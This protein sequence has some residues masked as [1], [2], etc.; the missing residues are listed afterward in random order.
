MTTRDRADQREPEDTMNATI[1]THTVGDGADSI[2]Y[3]VHGDPVAEAAHPPLFL[4]GSPMDAIGFGTLAGHFT[5]RTVITYDPRGAGRNPAGTAPLT[6]Q[7][8]AADLHRVIGAIGPGPVD[9]FA[10]SG[11]AVNALALA[12][13]HPEDVRTLVAHEPPTVVWLPDRD[14]ALA[15]VDDIGSTY[16][17]SGY[18]AAMAK[19]FAL[20]MHDGELPA[21]WTSRPAPDPAAFGLSTEDD[22]SRTD[23]LMRNART[24]TEF[25][26]DIQTLR[27]LG[28]RLV[29]AVGTESGDTL[30]ARGGR[31]VAA[32][33]GVPV[34]D[35]PS[36]HA[37]FVGGEYGQHG[38]PDA[39][40][41]R[42]R[43]ILAR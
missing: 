4:L 32:A 40:A 33:V 5:D 43:A 18:G 41:A 23:P 6:P 37:G 29:V 14:A 35:F 42:L 1:S 27:A 16:A 36:H 25:E 39:F 8:H 38:E 31:S 11:G 26:P 9:V 19:F 17:A 20:V 34:T 21:D 24:C 12:A 22:G 7:D 28:E 30:A 3:D 10:T 15:A 2:T 13:V